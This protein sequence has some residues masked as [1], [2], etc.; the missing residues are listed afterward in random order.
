MKATKKQS[1]LLLNLKSIFILMCFWV[2][3]LSDVNAQYFK[4]RGKYRTNQLTDWPVHYKHSATFNSKKKAILH[5]KKILNLNDI[6]TSNT[7]VEFDL[8][9]PIFSS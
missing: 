6:D 3:C 7:S 2:L 4:T 9:T 5:H 1:A 8:D